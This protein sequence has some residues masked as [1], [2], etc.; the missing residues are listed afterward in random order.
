LMV[1]WAG[2]LGDLFCIWRFLWLLIL[3]VI[4][5]DGESLKE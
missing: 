4:G 5:L 2:P 3:T 1:E